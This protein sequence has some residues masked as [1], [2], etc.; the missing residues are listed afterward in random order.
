MPI[1][2]GF[3]GVGQMAQAHIG[4]LSTLEDVEIVGIYDADLTRAR[5]VAN[6]I[7]ATV[8]ERADQVIDPSQVDAVFVCSPPFARGD[9]EE[10]AARNGIHILV[11]KPLGLNLEK[12]IR[13]ERVIQEKGII[14]SSG[15]CLRYLDTV[16]KVRS[17]LAD[18]QVDLVLGYYYGGLHKPGWW[19]QLHLSGG[20]F[21]DQSTHQVDLIRYLVSDIAEVHAQFERRAIHEEV[22]AATIY[23]VGTVSLK[24]KSGAIGSMSHACTVTPYT[25]SGLELLGHNF[26]VQL[27]GRTLRI[28]DQDQEITEVSHVN[29][30]LEQDKAFIQAVKSRSQEGIRSSYADALKTLAVT[31]APNQSAAAKTLV[32]LTTG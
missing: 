6:A 19:S 23:D 12:V 8:F 11:E 24:L 10:V 17:Y 26:Y 22:P 9:I 20:Q 7:N 5:E 14:N 4:A 21:V 27:D 30:I 25:R 29:F 1:R 18:K 15:Y 13:K 2:V 31:L 3:I 16:Q 32:S 28:I